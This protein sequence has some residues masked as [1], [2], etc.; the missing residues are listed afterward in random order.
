M[1]LWKQSK[2]NTNTS[3]RELQEAIT[4]QK[5]ISLKSLTK[6]IQ[7][8]NNNRKVYKQFNLIRFSEKIQVMEK[9]DNYKTLSLFSSNKE[10]NSETDKSDNDKILNKFPNEITSS[11]YNSS[12]HT[13]T[14][15]NYVP[16][17][18][19]QIK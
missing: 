15:N 4:I 1:K 7:E 14:S 5:V 8:N 19:T 17:Q 3:T 16:T 10:G 2:Y 18:Y 6:I 9:K 11:N 13:L 12:I